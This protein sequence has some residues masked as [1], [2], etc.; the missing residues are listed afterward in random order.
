MSSCNA[1]HSCAPPAN[2]SLPTRVLDVAR[3]KNGQIRLVVGA[4]VSAR[5]YV[6]LSH[7]WG[8]SHR[9]TTTRDNLDAHISG[10]PIANLPAT[11]QQAVEV[12]GLL[13]IPY[14]WIDSLCII[15][16]DARDWER[17]ASKMGGV[18]ANATLIIAADSSTDDSSGCYTTIQE[19]MQVSFV[20]SDNRALG[21]ISYANA[22]PLD[23]TPPYSSGLNAVGIGNFAILDHPP[24]GYLIFSQEWMPSSFNSSG[25]QS[26]KILYRTDEM[27]ATFDPIATENLSTRGWTFQER[28]L[29]SRT[30]HLTKGQMYWE[31]SKCMLAED[32]GVFPRTFPSLGLLTAYATPSSS[33]SEE[34]LPW[35]EISPRIAYSP[36]TA[37]ASEIWLCMVEQYTARKLTKEE[38]KLPALSGLARRMAN[39]TNDSYHAGLWR[40]D[41]AYGLA[42][43][44]HVYEPVHFCGNPEHDTEIAALTPAERCI[45]SH[46][47]AWRAPSWSWAAVDGQVE[48]QRLDHKI[49]VEVVE[50][51]TQLA[52]EDEFGMI[53]GGFV[54]VKVSFQT[55]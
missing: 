8:T 38:D 36:T 34:T 42:W 32:G 45:A 3:L 53:E 14:L 55:I 37:W 43:R 19:R 18:Y 17:E 33:S 52:G 12:T 26:G 41:L 50:C 23:N 40:R 27:G 13:G 6:A 25:F 51:R 31:C 47:R 15:Q 49:L 54:E 30:L 35:F 10:I 28:L 22:A 24:N 2:S 29:A 20:S 48:F 46:P 11:F 9:I 39:I 44:M 5:P 4:S 21:R 1:K 7:C 16:D